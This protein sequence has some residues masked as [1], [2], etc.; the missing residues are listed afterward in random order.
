MKNSFIYYCLVLPFVIT[1]C[2][3]FLVFCAQAIGYAIPFPSTGNMEMDADFSHN[4]SNIILFIFIFVV[5]A[6]NLKKIMSRLEGSY[7]EKIT[8]FVNGVSTIFFLIFAFINLIATHSILHTCGYQRTILCFLPKI[9]CVACNYP[10]CF[11]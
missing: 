9:Y 4:A 2:F 6:P 3:S 10:T 1:L 11:N 8:G 7:T 5:L